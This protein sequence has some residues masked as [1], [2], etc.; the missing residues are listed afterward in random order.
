MSGTFLFLPVFAAIRG[1]INEAEFSY[2]PA[3]ILVNKENIIINLV[4]SLSSI[5][6][7]SAA[8]AGMDNGAEISGS[9]LLRSS[10][11]IRVK[12]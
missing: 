9:Q 7:G 2:D 12:R 11:N 4:F 10:T 5:N 6:P 3:I 8:I 1:V